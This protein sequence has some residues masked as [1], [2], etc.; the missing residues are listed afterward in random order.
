MCN[1]PAADVKYVHLDD[2]GDLILEICDQCYQLSAWCEHSICKW[3]EEGTILS[4][5]LCGMDVT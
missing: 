5:N 3:N 4:C 1:H 2:E